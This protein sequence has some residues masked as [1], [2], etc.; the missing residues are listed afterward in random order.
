MKQGDIELISVYERMGSFREL[1]CSTPV[2]I[3]KI[4][5]GKKYIYLIPRG[6][7]Y[8][9]EGGH[10]IEQISQEK[11]DELYSNIKIDVFY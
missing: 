7:D 2:G 3:A 4:K 10:D 6:Y 11:F 5:I 1:T 9:C 8:N